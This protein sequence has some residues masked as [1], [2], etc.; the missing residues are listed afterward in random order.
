MAAAD[1]AL[2]KGTLWHALVHH[3]RALDRRPPSHIPFFNGNLFNPHFSEELVVSDDW[4]G[5]FLDELGDE[6]SPYLFSYIPVEILGTIYERFLGKVVRP[7]GR[8]VTI[9]EKPEVRKAGGVYYTPRYIVEYIVG[10]TVGKLLAGRKPEE[11]LKLRILDPACGS[12]SFLIRAFEEVC[13]H[14]QQWLTDHPDQRKKDWYWLEEN[15]VHLTTKAKRRILRDTIHGVDLD[16][17]AVEVTQLSLYLKMLENENRSTLAHEQDLFGSDEALLPP[18][19]ANIKCGNSLIAS[20]FSLVPDDLVRVHAFDWP[21]QF[22]TIMKA[23]GFDAVVGNP[24]YILLQDDFRDD[25]QLEYFR[26]AYEGASYKLDTYHLFIERGIRLCR[27]A[28]R[29][30]LITPSNFLTNNHLDGLR[31]VILKRTQPEEIVVVQG[32]VFA[33]VSVDNAVFVLR[34]GQP[35]TSPFPMTRAVAEAKGLKPSGESKVDPQ[36]VLAE[37]HAL[38]TSGVTTPGSVLWD[39]LSSHFPKLD[40]FADVNFGK[41]LRDRSK[42]TSDV[43]EVSGRR[44][45]PQTHVACVTGKDVERYLLTWSKLACLHDTVA[46]SGGCWDESKHEAKGK[47]LTRRIGQYPTFALDTVGYHCLNTIFMVTLREEAKIKPTFL[48]GVLNSKLLRGLWVGR[49]YDQRLTFPKIKGTYLKE[50]PI[51]L[52]D[53]SAA[54]DRVRHDRLAGLVDKMLALTPKLRAAKTDAERQTLQNAVTATDQQIDALVYEL[55][56]LTPEEIAL[57]EGGGKS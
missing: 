32:G 13:E 44:S 17:Q 14:C 34:A 27:K 36:R 5:G 25:Q 53:V 43:I 3:F 4:L 57:V 21:V 28:G 55:Y 19:E 23:G 50:L 7:H 37:A 47:L 30:S 8:G 20:D 51:A 40:D 6:E 41:Q 52:P 2:P 29:V 45:V 26:Q 16:P 11:A 15:A 38:F 31:K 35:A 54:G 1:C 10:Q 49:F 22:P 46:Q 9:E 24:P 48:L 18:L 39:R 33:G 12:G 56:G 42:F